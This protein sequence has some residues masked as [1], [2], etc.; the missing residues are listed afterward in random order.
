MQ[1]RKLLLAFVVLLS[2]CLGA[3][4]AYRH[5]YSRDSIAARADML[6]LLPAEANAVVFLDLAQFRSSPFLAQLFA[7]APRTTQD[8]EYAEFVRA[9]GFNYERDLDRITLATNGQSPH[10]SWFVIAEGRFDRAKIEAYASRSGMRISRSG[11]AVYSMQLNG[12]GSASYLTFLRDDRIGWTNEPAYAALF[13]RPRP[14]SASAEWRE[15]FTRLAGTPLFAVIRQ[16]SG[17]VSSFAAQAPSGLRSPQ[18]ATLLNQLQWISIGGKPDG[19]VLKVVIDGESVSEAT[20]RQLSE[21]VGG[22]LVLAQIGLNEAKTRKQLDPQLREACLELLR[23]TD[24][25]KMDR[26]TSK[27]VRIV[28]DVTPKLLE[29]ARTAASAAAPASTAATK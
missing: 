22:I 15:H 20:M 26:G 3:M 4:F 16:D 19:N 24:V 9:T 23:S 14:S 5:W 17:V 29:T 6:A 7:W 8:E 18:L 12:S 11:A 1:I 27:S 2:I 21:F 13:E 28:F 25:Q 10:S